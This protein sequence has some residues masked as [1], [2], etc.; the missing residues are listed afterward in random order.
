[1]ERNAKYIPSTTPC[2]DPSTC[3]WYRGIESDLA[4]ARE[5]IGDDDIIPFDGMVHE[6]CRWAKEEILRLRQMLFE[7]H[8]CATG[9][10]KDEQDCLNCDHHD[11]VRCLIDGEQIW[12][13]IPF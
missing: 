8:D 9:G 13:E 5:V 10:V 2:D 12:D 4:C 6:W 11:T 1:M 3:G 7:R